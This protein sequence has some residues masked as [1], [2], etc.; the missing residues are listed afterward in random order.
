[1][2]ELTHP[3][4]CV[5]VCLSFPPPLMLMFLFE[6]LL[7]QLCLIKGAQEAVQYAGVAL[8]VQL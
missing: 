2:Q 8:Y 6:T 1:M 4:V 7:V 3:H 5:C